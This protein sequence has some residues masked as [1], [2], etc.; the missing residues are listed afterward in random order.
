MSNILK[1]KFILRKL[2]F[3]SF[4][5]FYFGNI[6]IAKT[7]EVDKDNPAINAKNNLVV[8]ANPERKGYKVE[9]NTGSRAKLYAKDEN[10]P[11][12]ASSSN[13]VLEE[14]FKKNLAP[15][16][17]KGYGATAVALHDVKNTDTV[18]VT[19]NNVGNY[20]K[21]PV[22]AIATYS[23]IKY[24]D[25]PTDYDYPMID[26]SENLFSGN[27]F[28]NVGS[29]N[30]DLEFRLA[31]TD[32]VIEFNK[33]AYIGI[34][35]LNMGEFAD[36]S[37]SKENN[38][39]I[40]NDSLVKYQGVTAATGVTGDYW[41]GSSN[42]FI[43]KIGS[44]NFKK[45]TVSFQIAGKKQSFTL[46]SEHGSGWMSISSATLFSVEP[47]NPTKT[48]VNT[49]GKDINKIQV[50]HGQIISYLI[51]QRINTLGQD[52]LEKY[53][54]FIIEDTLPENVTFVSSEVVDEKG[55]IIQ[56]VG[57]IN[58]DNKSNKVKYTANENMLKNIM[59]YTGETYSLKINVKIN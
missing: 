36:Y 32:E 25:A 3:V 47:E 21:K 37:K 1:E 48:V 35:S 34:N 23:N 16:Y 33:D 42:D 22:K 39:Y 18:T 20:N 45:A 7:I 41:R 54:T 4:I 5:F 11:L 55:N 29:F 12:N 8:E 59:Q 17:V 9:T 2:I 30:Y 15:N 58:F 26:I 43:D 6:V 56:N 28:F 38:V 19:Y 27:I 10:A 40:T 50:Q 53:S 24:F 49:Q 14:N 31:E 44:E 57:S 13:Y 46:G 52:L 51:N